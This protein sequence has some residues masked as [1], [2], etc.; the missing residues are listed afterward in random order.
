VVSRGKNLRRVKRS[1]MDIRSSSSLRRKNSENKIFLD[2]E[3][4]ETENA[5]TTLQSNIHYNTVTTIHVNPS[6]M[7]IQYQMHIKMEEER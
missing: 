1:A 6:I 4:Q 2:S 3:L 7:N 5:I